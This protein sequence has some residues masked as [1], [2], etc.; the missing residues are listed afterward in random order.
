ML[1]NF[2]SATT[3]EYS[4][5][6]AMLVHILFSTVTFE[7][8][9][10]TK[11][12]VTVDPSDGLR[13]GNVRIGD[14]RAQ[15]LRF[16]SPLLLVRNPVYLICHRLGAELKFR[17]GVNVQPYSGSPANFAVYTTTHLLTRASWASA[18]QVVGT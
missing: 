12:G 13:H 15:V 17:W 16:S 11:D 10:L 2:T 18:C 7:F 3:A 4:R 6:S 1:W 14:P 9:R 8:Q 5:Q